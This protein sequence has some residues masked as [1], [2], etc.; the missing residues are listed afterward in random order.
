MKTIVFFGGKLHEL[1]LEKESGL[2]LDPEKPEDRKLIR[3]LLR[4]LMFR[5]K[6]TDPSGEKLRELVEQVW[7]DVKDGIRLQ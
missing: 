2:H 1:D 5:L 3:E 4:E 7:H 6:R